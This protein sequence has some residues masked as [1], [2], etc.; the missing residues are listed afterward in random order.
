MTNLTVTRQLDPVLLDILRKVN[1]V[2]LALQV[3]YYLL[4]ALA[5]DVVL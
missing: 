4:G 2:M 1:A 3:D 5:R